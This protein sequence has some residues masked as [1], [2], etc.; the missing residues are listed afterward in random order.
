MQDGGEETCDIATRCL[1][2]SDEE[3]GRENWAQRAS[4]QPLG[5]I[6]F[7]G[8]A[9]GGLAWEIWGSLTPGEYVGSVAGAA[10]LVAVGHGIRHHGKP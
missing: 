1:S 7:V 4:S 6:A 5:H 2:T 9:I 10:G 3:N 8:L